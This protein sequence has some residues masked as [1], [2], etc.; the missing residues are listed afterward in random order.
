M[1]HIPE[2]EAQRV[3]R[4]RSPYLLTW[5]ACEVALA[6][7]AFAIA[8]TG[9]VTQVIGIAGGGRTPAERLAA[10]LRAPVCHV[11]A[12]HNTSDELY[13]Q[14][15]G[16]VAV[17]I[18]DSFPDTVSGRV[19]LADDICGTGAT[20]TAVTSALTPRLTPDTRIQTTALC[21][22]VGSPLRPCWWAWDVDDWVVFPW[23]PRPDATGRLLPAPERISTP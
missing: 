3:F 11:D 4:R 1:T 8:E 21:R 15:T 14:A 7:M 22:N 9:P 23:E 17:S 19:L 2:H 10:H 13:T 18:P 5:E 16:A 12:R 20:F 6:Q